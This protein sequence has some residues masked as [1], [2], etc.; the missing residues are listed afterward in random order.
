MRKIALVLI[1]VAVILSLFSA[2]GLV[3]LRSTQPVNCL[4]FKQEE[5]S[6]RASFVYGCDMEQ[7]VGDGMVLKVVNL[8]NYVSLFGR[9]YLNLVQVKDGKVESHWYLARAFGKPDG[10]LLIIK[11]GRTLSTDPDEQRIFLTVGKI[12]STVLTGN[13]S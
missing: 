11:T 3:K 5:P 9:L 7:D 10:M 4:T 8:R 2:W 1:P 13:A 6:G 12:G